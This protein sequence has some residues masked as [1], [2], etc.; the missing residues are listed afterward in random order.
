VFRYWKKTFIPTGI[1]AYDEAGPLSGNVPPMTIFRLDTPGGA[2]CEPASAV[3]HAIAATA[4]IA[5]NNPNLILMLCSFNKRR[6]DAVS[7]RVRQ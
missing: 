2:A 4:S 5:A 6:G 3:T 1:G 7:T